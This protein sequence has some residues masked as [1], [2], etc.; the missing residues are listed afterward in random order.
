M[1]ET[2]HLDYTQ[3]NGSIPLNFPVNPHQ[4]RSYMEQAGYQHDQSYPMTILGHTE[5]AKFL[6]LVKSY[7]NVI[8]IHF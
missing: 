1:H 2:K 6:A 3:I 5:G 4:G 8:S 7:E